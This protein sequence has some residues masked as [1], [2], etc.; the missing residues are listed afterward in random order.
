MIAENLMYGLLLFTIVLIGSFIGT[1]M[2][3]LMYDKII[4][5]LE[6]QVKKK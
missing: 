5:Y 3:F 6:N 4:T 1:M 2:A